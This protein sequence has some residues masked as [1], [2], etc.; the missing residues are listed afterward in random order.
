MKCSRC[1]RKLKSAAVI[2]GGLT[3]G[4]TCS[5]I[6][7]ISLERIKRSRAPVLQDGQLPLFEAVPA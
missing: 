3:L 5:R 6:L 1:H 4:P 7:G 2:S